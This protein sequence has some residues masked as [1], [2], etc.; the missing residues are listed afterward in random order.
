M[1]SYECHYAQN[2]N[3]HGDHLKKKKKS[4]ESQIL[5]VGSPLNLDTI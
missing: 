2:N 5:V 4:V 1:D 3:L